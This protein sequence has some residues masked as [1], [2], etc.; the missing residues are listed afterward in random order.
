MQFVVG[1]TFIDRTLFIDGV[2]FERCRFVQCQFL[3]RAKDPALFE[4]CTL[5]QCEW[6]FKDAAENMFALLS[7]LYRGTNDEGRSLVTTIF[8]GIKD[9]ALAGEIGKRTATVP[10]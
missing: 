3:Y 9:G 4:D 5:D 1:E 7:S 6:V 2:T 10:A 8:E